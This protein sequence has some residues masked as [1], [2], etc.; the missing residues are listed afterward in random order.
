MDERERASGCESETA[1]GSAP[2]PGDLLSRAS[3]LPE[4]LT[5]REVADF[6]RIRNKRPAV[7]SALAEIGVGMVRLSRRVWRVR[8]D[9]LLRA[10]EASERR[11]G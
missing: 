5:I 10:L 3:G 7:D 4:L 9:S 2:A 6:L 8:R 1:G 11:A